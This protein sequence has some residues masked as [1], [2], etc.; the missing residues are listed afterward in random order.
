MYAHKSNVRSSARSQANSAAHSPAPRAARPSPPKAPVNAAWSRLATAS[1]AGKILRTP[2][3]D[4]GSYFEPSPAGR[5]VQRDTFVGGAGKTASDKVRPVHTF[6]GAL[7]ASKT[8]GGKVMPGTAT[9]AQ[10]C[11]GDS[12]SAKKWIN[13]PEL[14]FEA[15]DGV[16]RPPQLTANWTA[17]QAFVPSGCTR[18]ENAGVTVNSTRCNSSSELELVAFLYRWPAGSFSDPVTQTSQVVYQSD[19]HMMGRSVASLP[20][21]W[22][23]KMDKRESVED[24]RDPVQSLHDAY[25]HTKQADREIKRFTFCCD[26]SGLKTTP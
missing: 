26:P 14:G 7:P 2:K 10:N 20:S 13:W 4:A 3:P 6:P 18:V 22:H 8:P 16:S 1:L 5:K 23:S 9:T 17:A 24:I 19:F 21:G 25:P 15:D 12:I 11:A